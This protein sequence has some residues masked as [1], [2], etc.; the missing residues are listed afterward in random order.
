[1][2]SSSANARGC[3]APFGWLPALK[4]LNLPLARWFRID[5]ARM[6]RAE[7][8]V[9]KNKTL[10]GRSLTVPHAARFGVQQG[11]A[12]RAVITSVP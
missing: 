4:A 2:R 12:A 3:T 9:H 5:S 6:L 7:F 8:P 11:F 10:Y 1:M